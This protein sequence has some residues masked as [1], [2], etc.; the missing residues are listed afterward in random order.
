MGLRYEPASMTMRV[1]ERLQGVKRDNHTV[2]MMLALYTSEH[3]S[4][5]LGSDTK[6]RTAPGA[7]L[8]GPIISPILARRR[9][10]AIAP[11]AVHHG[12]HTLHPRIPPDSVPNKCS[13]R[14]LLFSK[15]KTFKNPGHPTSQGYP[16]VRLGIPASKPNS[17]RGNRNNTA[18]IEH[19]RPKS[20]NKS[21]Q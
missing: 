13:C 19:T 7:R 8:L 21:S 3:P 12:P 4:P 17:A 6:A 10:K 15:R 11:I 18:Y 2:P 9:G 20:S 1:E 16:N 5:V 14:E